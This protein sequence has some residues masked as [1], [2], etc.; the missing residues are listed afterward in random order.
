M[1]ALRY[2]D[3]LC[4]TVIFIA[5]VLGCTL[6]QRKIAVKID[7]IGFAISP[8]AQLFLRVRQQHSTVKTDRDGAASNIVFRLN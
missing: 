4:G 8:D 7:A 3:P 5:T 1:A 6:L 2:C